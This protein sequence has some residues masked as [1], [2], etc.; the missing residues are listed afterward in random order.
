MIKN[1]K[2][3]TLIEILAVIIII[4]ILLII[5]VPSVSRYI[6]ESRQKSYVAT[7]KD[8]LVSA[9][10]NLSKIDKSAINRETTYYIPIKCINTENGIPES[11]Y[12]E[13]D[14]AYIVAGWENNNYGFYFYGRDKS[15]V[16]V[17]SLVKI[18]DFEVD[19]LKKNIKK[20][21]IEIDKKIGTTTKIAIL[22]EDDC[23][24]IIEEVAIE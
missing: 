5:I 1:N 11:P 18:N 20:D 17:T 15:G 3:F 6:E 8:T 24:T 14:N 10:S 7:I 4:A 19:D 21:D 16:G 2:G 13:F 22:D 23:K 12:N 9:G